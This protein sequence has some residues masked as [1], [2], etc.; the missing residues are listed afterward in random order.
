[1]ATCLEVSLY[2]AFQNQNTVHQTQRCWTGRRDLQYFPSIL[3]SFYCRDVRVVTTQCEYRMTQ[4]DLGNTKFNLG[5]AS[6][7]KK[8]NSNTLLFLVK[9]LRLPT[10]LQFG[11]SWYLVGRMSWEHSAVNAVI[12]SRFS[13]TA[14][15][16]LSLHL[17]WTLV[18][19]L[20]L[21]LKKALLDGM[22]H[23]HTPV[24]FCTERVGGKCNGDHLQLKPDSKW[25]EVTANSNGTIHKFTRYSTLQH[26]A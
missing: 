6:K 24:H 19:V 16:I 21:S 11:K 7:T 25:V 13:P 9:E 23:K 15:L 5:E 26:L 8:Q 18:L 20:L 1:M 3:F 4:T 10:F 22:K 2:S 12:F 17:S 14:H